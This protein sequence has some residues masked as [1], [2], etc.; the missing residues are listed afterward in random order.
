MRSTRPGRLVVV[1]DASLPLLPVFVRLLSAPQDTRQPSAGQ[2]LLLSARLSQTAEAHLS[3]EACDA[4]LLP[5]AGD[6][7]LQIRHGRLL[8]RLHPEGR[9]R[10]GRRQVPMVPLAARPEAGRPAVA[11]LSADDRRAGGMLRAATVSAAAVRRLQPDRLLRLDVLPG[12]DNPGVRQ[13]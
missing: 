1:Q 7:H 9:L 8:Q 2:L 13:S 6:A 12:P 5:R 10:P 11:P 4:R 3:A